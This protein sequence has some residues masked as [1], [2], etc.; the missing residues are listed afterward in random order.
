VITG[1]ERLAAEPL[2]AALARGV[3]TVR[4]LAGGDGFL[5]EV[6]DLDLSKS[7]RIEVTTRRQGP[8]LLLDPDEAERNV[9]SYLGL[10][11]ELQQEVGP[12]ATVDLRWR[13]RISVLPLDKESESD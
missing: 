13:D 3:G 8:R 12:L 11:S 6:S 10:R 7:D 1:V 5:D 4:R 9:R 2:R